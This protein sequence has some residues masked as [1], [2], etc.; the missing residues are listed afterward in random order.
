MLF[1]GKVLDART[2]SV[3]KP[4][5]EVVAQLESVMLVMKAEAGE[6]VKTLVVLVVMAEVKA[7]VMEMT[8]SAMVL[9]VQVRCWL[10]TLLLTVHFVVCYI[11]LLHY[12]VLHYSVSHCLLYSLL[13]Y[14]ITL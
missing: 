5:I 11:T 7:L 13:H 2:R 12:S 4:G 9:T 8:T 14:L 6:K 1:G 10:G 3:V